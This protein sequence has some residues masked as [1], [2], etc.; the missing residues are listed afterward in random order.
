MPGEVNHFVIEPAGGAWRDVSLEGEMGQWAGYPMF[1]WV[2]P[3][4]PIPASL[5][6]SG[7]L[8]SFWPRLDEFETK[9]YSRHLV[10][11]TTAAGTGV[12]N[13]YVRATDG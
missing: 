13:C 3:G 7:T 8:P 6:E 10:P 5:V 4:E 2:T 12:T 9:R 11:F 1:E